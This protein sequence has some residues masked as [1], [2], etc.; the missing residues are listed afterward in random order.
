MFW[1]IVWALQSSKP[2]LILSFSTNIPNSNQNQS[3][4]PRHIPQTIVLC[5]AHAPIHASIAETFISCLPSQMRFL[6]YH[7]AP[8]GLF[9]RSTKSPYSSSSKTASKDEGRV[10]ILHTTIAR[11][12]RERA[13]DRNVLGFLSQRRI[14]SILKA[15]PFF[16]LLRPRDP[17][18]SR[19]TP[20][21]ASLFGSLPHHNGDHR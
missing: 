11:M 6:I 3:R 18:Q 19:E 17:S 7:E 4:Q 8:S 14:N 15:I 21:R 13:S 12:A 16:L 20:S 1:L 2:R 9:V 10:P 5:A